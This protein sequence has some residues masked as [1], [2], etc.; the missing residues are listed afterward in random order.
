MTNT[1]FVCLCIL[2]FN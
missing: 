1:L 2:K